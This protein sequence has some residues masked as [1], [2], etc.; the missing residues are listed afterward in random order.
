MY[1]A[2][3]MFVI[4]D[5]ELYDKLVTA[6]NCGWWRRYRVVA[7]SG[8][9]DSE[10]VIETLDNGAHAY[11]SK[12]EGRDHLVEAVL[13]A[14][15]DQPYVMPVRPGRWLTD[16]GAQPPT[17]EARGAG[18][19][20]V[21]QGGVEDLDPRRM[22]IKQNI[23]SGGTWAHAEKS[24]HRTSSADKDTLLSHTILDGVVKAGSILPYIS[25][26]RHSRPT[27]VPAGEFDPGHPSPHWSYGHLP[28]PGRSD[29]L[30]GRAPS[31][32]ARTVSVPDQGGAVHRHPIRFCDAD[33]RLADPVV[34][35]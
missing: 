35:R 8:R 3:A 2:V 23:R 24:G 30:D 6:R 14:S 1:P 31:S 26:Q 4:L 22:S 13:P 17:V 7:F 15:A 5:L 20:A 11:V 19:A 34:G 29:Q 25:S 16:P 18:A 9:S 28:S 12:E 32:M 33:Q 21:D 10:I 27:F